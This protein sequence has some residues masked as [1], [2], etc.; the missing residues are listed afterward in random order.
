MAPAASHHDI[1]LVWQDSKMPLF[2][3]FGEGTTPEVSHFSD[4]PQKDAW[5]FTH[6]SDDDFIR[7]VN[8]ISATYKQREYG[9][10]EQCAYLRNLKGS[11]LKVIMIHSVNITPKW[12]H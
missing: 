9:M 10:S 3:H 5:C 2:Q 11:Q 8:E 1:F 6:K 12:N 4:V 7:M